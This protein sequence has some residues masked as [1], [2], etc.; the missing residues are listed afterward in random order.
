MVESKQ[1]RQKKT[2]EKVRKHRAKLRAQGLRPIQI[3]VPDVHSPEFIAEARRQSQMLAESPYAREDQE[4]VDAISWFNEPE[5]DAYFSAPHADKKRG[6]IWNAAGSPDYAGKPRPVAIVQEEFFEEIDSVTVCPFT[7]DLRDA[8]VRIL[9]K[10][11]D[12]NGLR[13]QSRIMADKIVTLHHSKLGKRMGRLAN[14]DIRRLNRAMI[15][16]LGLAG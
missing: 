7:I 13:S 1:A 8:L 11:S 15:V 3:W 6:E 10:P 16:F 9:V 14:D 4:F 5:S 2:R 12:M